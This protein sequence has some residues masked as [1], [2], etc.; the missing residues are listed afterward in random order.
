MVPLDKV[1]E[2][3]DLKHTRRGFT[4]IELLIVIAII[5]V[6][7][8]V[9][10][11]SLTFARQKSRDGK[12]IAEVTQ[13][14]R[15]LELF[16]DTNQRYPSTTPAGFT[17]KDAGIKLLSSLGFLPS[18]P[19][20][21][22]PGINPTYIYHGIYA[23]AGTPAECLLAVTNCSGYELG[24]TLERNDNSVLLNDAD[25]SVGA[26]YGAYPDCDVNAAGTETCY[27]VKG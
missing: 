27:D 9:I 22:P 25:Q 11:A 16:Y 5:G 2:I 21:P 7:S 15:A 14:V 6:L 19:P 3:K 24:I 23:N 17:G 18:T 10:L 26:F 8:S 4:L 1:K 20:V 13:M 12:R